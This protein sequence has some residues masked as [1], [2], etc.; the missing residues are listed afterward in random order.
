MLPVLPTIPFSS[1]SDVDL[2]PGLGRSPGSSTLSNILAW[3]S[4]EQRR[5]A[6]YSPWSHRVGH[7]LATKQQQQICFVFSEESHC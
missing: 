2:T 7:D 6:G 4:H 5:L 3:E 1:L